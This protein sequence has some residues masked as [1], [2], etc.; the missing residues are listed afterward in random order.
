MPIDPEMMIRMDEARTLINQG[1]RGE[2]SAVVESIYTYMESV[3]EA[4]NSFES[5]HVL[6]SLAG[7]LRALGQTD[8]EIKVL[9]RLCKVADDDLVKKGILAV[10]DDVRWTG[11]DFV[12]LGVAYRKRQRLD[13]ARAALEKARHLL[14]ELGWECDV[15][16]I[17][18]GESTHIG[19][20]SSVQPKPYQWKPDDEDKLTGVLEAMARQDEYFRQHLPA[21]IRDKLPK[22]IFS[23]SPALTSRPASTNS[24]ARLARWFKGLLGFR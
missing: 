14:E 6:G 13:D 18:R 7:L 20:S 17:L 22:G 2:A 24:L 21:S 23:G 8:R 16:K 12:H 15:E 5:M 9:E 4:F 3:W 1:E 19:P 11:M 10:D